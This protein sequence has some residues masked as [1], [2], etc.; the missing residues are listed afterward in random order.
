M[1][2]KLRKVGHCIRVLENVSYTVSGEE[3]EGETACLFENW[4]C[5][6]AGESGEWWYPRESI[7]HLNG[8][9]YPAL[10]YEDSYC[11]RFRRL[12]RRLRGWQRRKRRLK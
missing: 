11:S 5:V 8:N 4:V 2:V 3:C 10:K 7:E 1:K 12:A 9:G 6:E